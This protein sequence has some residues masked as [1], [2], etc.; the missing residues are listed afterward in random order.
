M[1]FCWGLFNWGQLKRFRELG[2]YERVEVGWDYVKN[3]ARNYPKREAIVDTFLGVES[4][5]RRRKTW[6]QVY[7]ENN[8]I[9]FNLLDLGIKKEDVVVTQLPNTIENFYTNIFTSKLGAIHPCL[10]VEM[11]EVETKATLE[12]ID[13]NVAI[14][15]PSYRGQDFAGWYREYQQSHPQLKHIFAV[16]KPGEAIP[17]GT[18]PFTDLLDEKIYKRYSEEDLNSLQT[19][20]LEPQLV[21]PSGGTTGIPKLS[22]Q[23]WRFYPSLQGEG[24]INRMGITPYDVLLE[25]G[26]INGGTGRGFGVVVPLIRGCKVVYLTEYDDENACMISEDEKV[27]L[28]VGLPAQMIRAATS[29]YFEKYNLSCLRAVGYAGAPLPPEVGEMLWSKGIKSF[30]SYGAITTPMCTMVI[31]A[32]ANKETCL[33]T[34]GKPME[35]TDLKVVDDKGNRLPPGGYGEVLLWGPHFGFYNSPELTNVNYDED[36]WEHTGDIGTLDKQ[37]NIKIVGR[38]KDMILRGGQN[39][40]PK[41]IEDLLGQHP[42]VRQVAIVAMPDKILGE[43]ACAY[44]VPKEG[45]T[46]TFEEMVSLLEE[47]KVTKWKWPERLEIIKELPVSTGGKIKKDVLKEDITEKLRKEGKI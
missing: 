19:C 40:F 38:S 42:K 15:L 30:G 23:C 20:S 10:Q 2:G 8:T 14:I 47:Q 26:P 46:F 27:T 21:T 17:E 9:I 4:K 29:P 33:F 12:V 11:G 39:I 28:W 36:G 16:T 34:S 44:V 1:P 13:P 35:G 31:P 25:F 45:E 43:R 41:E 3:N 24:Y 6:E 37:G 5:R 7:K 18:R 32:E 22:I